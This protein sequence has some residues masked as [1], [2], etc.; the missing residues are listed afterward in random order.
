MAAMQLPLF[1]LSTVLFPRQ[2]LSL[3]IFERRY[4]LLI[5]KCL[6]QGKAFGVVLIKEGDEAGD[7]AVPYAVGTTA[8]IIE[9]EKLGDG[10]MNVQTVGEQRFRILSTYQQQPYLQGTVE[11]LPEEIGSPAQVE[12][13]VRRLRELYMAHLGLQQMLTRE[14]I[15]VTDLGLPY[16]PVH[17]SYFLAANL[18]LSRPQKQ[19]LLE[20]PTAEQRLAETAACLSR[21]N[22]VLR[23]LAAKRARGEGPPEFPNYIN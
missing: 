15:P 6:Q 14:P 5:Q 20:L 9:V 11:L 16:D 10:R 21:E 4:R 12:E 23:Y 2:S 8:Q 3:H 17:L 7:L 1:P 18:N 13:L 22:A 19:S